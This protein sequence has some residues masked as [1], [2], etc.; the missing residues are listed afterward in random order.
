MNN[1]PDALLR[2]RHL[3]HEDLLH[4]QSV[5]LC[6]SLQPASL[7]GLSRAQKSCEKLARYSGRY[8]Q[9]GETST[10]RVRVR[11]NY[12]KLLA[13]A[14]KMCPNEP[15]SRFTALLSPSLCVCEKKGGPISKI[16][17]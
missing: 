1:D 11:T 2:A 10:V 12:Y 8:D 9:L 6:L 13:W 14:Q 5:S 3:A 15:G 7:V 16:I 17:S 4:R